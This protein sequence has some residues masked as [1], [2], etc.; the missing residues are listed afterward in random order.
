VA[1]F[2]AALFDDLNAP[3]AMAAM[4]TFITRMNAELDKGGTDA[5]ALSRAREAFATMDGV[6]DIVPDREVADQGLAAWVEERLAARKAAR[7]ARNFAE[8]DRIRGELLE[9][10][11]VIEDGPS[12]TTWKSR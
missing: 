12:G 7:A 8:A 5:G 3:N 11:I 4:F 10:G 1:E 9:K 2:R 6:L